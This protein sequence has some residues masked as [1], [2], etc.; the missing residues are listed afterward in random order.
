MILQYQFSETFLRFYPNRTLHTKFVQICHKFSGNIHRT[1]LIIA[2]LLTTRAYTM[3]LYYMF[4]WSVVRD[5]GGWEIISLR[6]GC[7]QRLL[8][9]LRF[10]SFWRNI[11][12][13]YCFRFGVAVHNNI[14]FVLKTKFIEM[15]GSSTK[16]FSIIDLIIIT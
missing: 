14:M 13:I 10:Q 4:K 5:E 1:L 3:T 12:I 11:I 7:C 9:L 16:Q 6:I 15:S 8:Y 2:L